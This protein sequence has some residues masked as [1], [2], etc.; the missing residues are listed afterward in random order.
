MLKRKK[1][2]FHRARS[3]NNWPPYRRFQKHCKR[4]LR[5]AEWKYI[6]GTIQEGLDRNDTKPFWRFIKARKQDNAG[7]APLKT[8]GQLH[9]DSQSKADI[10]L[11]QFKSVFTKAS[12]QPLPHLQSTAPDIP[13]ITITVPGVTKL[14][15][16]LKVNKA[17]GSDGIPNT[18]LKTL[19]DSVGPALALIF[20]TSVDSG[21]LPKDW[22]SAN[23]SCAF[24]KGDRHEPA[25]YRPISLTSVLCKLL[26]HIIFRHIMSHFQAHKIL[27]NLN[28]G[29][30]SGYSTETQLLTTTSDLLQ[31]FDQGKQIDMA[32]LDF[33]KAFDIVPHDR[34]LLKL[35]NYGIT[36]PLHT[37]L[38][39]F[40]AERSMQVVVEGS[41]SQPTI[42]DS[43][44]PQ[45]T[46]LGPLLFLS[47][48]NDL[49]QA[50]RSQVRLFAD[51]CLVYR[52]I[53]TFN[54]H[55]TLQ[56]DLK[57]LESWTEKWGMR[58]NAT[59]CYVRSISHKPPS[60]FMYS[61]NNTILKTVPSNPYL[62]ILFSD[63]LKWRNHISSITK[64]ANR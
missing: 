26:E 27:T 25:N 29:F 45:G 17:S 31:S 62:G 20:Q 15:R 54:D 43:G 22:L 7:V 21:R 1:R 60:T 11:N 53:D 56:E 9:S 48:I 50:V 63:N 64:K 3:S 36:G 47:H 34:L 23:V 46:V 38:H 32:I 16:Q 28:H 30:R 35:A 12:S 58:F 44:V 42:V 4:E 40:L 2:L 57:R 52:E 19:A 41:T 51:D 59:K 5:R 6:N 13:P 61:L 39:C 33:S 55:H 14:L 37:W 24:K 18:V 49:P 10:L 8:K